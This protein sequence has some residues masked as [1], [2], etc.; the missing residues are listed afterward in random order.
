MTDIS[1]LLLATI[2][3]FPHFG[4]RINIKHLQMIGDEIKPI[5]TD[6]ITW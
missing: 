5:T 3:P 2:V 4:R 6:G 1:K